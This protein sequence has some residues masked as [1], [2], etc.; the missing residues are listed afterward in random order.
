MDEKYKSL[1]IQEL[2]Q[3]LTN[4]S[5]ISTGTIAAK[6]EDIGFSCLMCGKCCRREF[7]DN[8]VLLI[9]QEIQVISD[10]TILEA[11]EIAT[12]A[13]SDGSD[14]DLIDTDGKI[15]T[16]GWMLARKSNGDCNFIED[17]ETSNKC[18]IHDVRPML[19]HTYPFYMQDMELHVSECEGLG[20]KIS[21]EES[22]TIA[23]DV[24]SRYITEIEDTIALYQKFEG[25][26]AGKDD[27]EI[28][29][30]KAAGKCHVAYVVHDSKGTH[31]VAR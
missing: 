3:E 31:E 7:G 5:N 29:S 13:T 2:K 26:T 8:R 22:L 16:F 10:H 1:L 4:A 14:S 25:F 12:P 6:I 28:T 30:G 9:P 11:H 15:H 27:L 21:P 18:T 24:A 19:C 20:H 23:H 17:A